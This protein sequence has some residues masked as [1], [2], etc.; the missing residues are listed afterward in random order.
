MKSGATILD[1]S[2][3]FKVACIWSDCRIFLHQCFQPLA[4]GFDELGGVD[5]GGGDAL[6]EAGE[7]FGHDA[8]V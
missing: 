6:A 7:V 5:G 8:V 4:D 3:A 1:G 2:A